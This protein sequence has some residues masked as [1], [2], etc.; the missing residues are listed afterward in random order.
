MGYVE[1]TTQYA[2]PADLIK[3]GITAAALQH[4]STGLSAQNAQLLAASA[5]ID[6]ALGQRL[7]LPVVQWG[8]DVV[9]NCCWLA[10]FGLIQLRGYDPEN[11]NDQIYRQRYDLACE[12]LEKV[13]VDR[14]ACTAIGSPPGDTI[15][16][17]KEPQVG[18]PALVNF[19]TGN[20]TR[21]TQ[22]RR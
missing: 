21:G 4:P 7:N 10:T 19:S 22:W 16:A 9:M 11:K 17:P 8:D 12:W 1:T 6:A 14:F 20:Q 3:Y 18:S 5:R 15:A 2:Q 13:K